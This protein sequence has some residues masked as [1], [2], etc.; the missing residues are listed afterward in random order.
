MQTSQVI[1]L[2]D[3]EFRV[4]EKAKKAKINNLYII[5]GFLH[6]IPFPDGY[7]DVMITSHALGWH[8]EEELANLN[9]L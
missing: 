2:L 7:F 8:L 5:D 4:K 6:S 1:D 3:R 9:A